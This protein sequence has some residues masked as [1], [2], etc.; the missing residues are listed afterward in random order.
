MGI[1]DIYIMFLF[2][3]IDIKL[4][5]NYSKTDIYV[6]FRIKVEALNGSYSTIK[7]PI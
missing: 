1:E 5:Q 6:R 4:C 3:E 2:W 7:Q